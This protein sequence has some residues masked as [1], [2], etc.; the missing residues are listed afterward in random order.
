MIAIESHLPA[1]ITGGAD[2]FT[3]GGHR[4]ATSETSYSSPL[5]YYSSATIVAQPESTVENMKSRSLFDCNIETYYSPLATTATVVYMDNNKNAIWFNAY[6]IVLADLSTYPTSWKL[7]GSSNQF[8]W[9][10][11]HFVDDF[12]PNTSRKYFFLV[13]NVPHLY[14]YFKIQFLSSSSG[15]S[16]QV[17]E[18]NLHQINYQPLSDSLSYEFNVYSGF[19]H[20]DSL[21]IYPVTGDYTNFSILP[22]LP[23]SLTFT[24]S[25]HIF[26]TPTEMI[27]RAF[28]IRAFNQRTQSFEEISLDLHFILCEP[29][30]YAFLKLTKHN[31]AFAAE[32]QFFMYSSTNALLYAS[33]IF[34][35]NKH[36]VTNLCVPADI[37]RIQLNDTSYDGWYEYS[38]L[39]IHMQTFDGY[40]KLLMTL[41]YP[42]GSPD[43]YY[44]DT[45]YLIYE[46]SPYWK[47]IQ[48]SIPPTWYSLQDPQEF[49]ILP[50]PR[51]SATSNIWLF[52]HSFTIANKNPY[53]S[54]DI[55]L[56]F[57]AGCIIYINGLSVYTSSLPEGE[58][59]L[60][61][62][63]TSS[64]PESS[65]MTITVDICAFRIG[66]NSVAIGLVNPVEQTSG[67]IDF[68]CCLQLIHSN[69]VPR[70]NAMQVQTVPNSDLAY[71]LIDKIVGGNWMVTVNRGEVA[72]ITLQFNKDRAEY[73]NEYCFTSSSV[74]SDYDPSDW[75]V[76][77]SNDNVQY[78]HIGNYTNAYFSD[79]EIQRCF[80]LPSN[81]KSWTYYKFVLT[82][83]ANADLPNY[84]FALSE[85]VLDTI[86]LEALGIPNLKFDNAYYL[87]YIGVPFPDLVPNSKYFINFSI[88]PNLPNPLEIDTTTGSIRGIPNA[89]LP[90]R[91]YEITAV[92]PLDILY[93]TQIEL[94]VMACVSPKIM[95]TIMIFGGLDAAETGFE[96]LNSSNQTIFSKYVL[97]PNQKSYFPFCQETGVYSLVLYDMRMNGWGAG[98]YSVLLEDNSVLMTGSIRQKSKYQ[99]VVLNLGYVINPLRSH[100]TYLN[101]AV[102]PP[103]TWL[104]S[105]FSDPSWSVGTANEYGESVGITQY[106]RYVFSFKK[107]ANYASVI[108]TIH[109]KFGA[110]VYLNGDLLLTYNMPSVTSTHMTPCLQRY[111]TT[112]R[113]GESFSLFSRPLH[114][115]EN[116][117]AVEIHKSDSTPEVIDFDADLQLTATNS[118]RVID[119]TASTDVA[120]DPDAGKVFDNFQSTTYTSNKKCEGSQFIWTYNKNRKEFITS[121]TL[122]SDP[123]CNVYHPSGW[124][125]EGSNNM[126]QWSMLDTQTLQ[127]FTEY[128][129]TKS[130]TFYNEKAFN[131]YRL[132]VT[133][134]NNTPIG[135]AES[136]T[137]KNCKS[138]GS[139][140]QLVDI[141]LYTT[142]V[143]PSC[144]P[145]DGFSGAL[146]GQYAYKDCDLYYEGTYEALCLD[147]QLLQAVDH[148]SLMKPYAILYS[149][150]I[151]DFIQGNYA[152]FIPTVHAIKYTCAST[153]LP[154]GISM[155]S[156]T[157]MLYGETKETFVNFRVNVTCT[158]PA[159]SVSTFIKLNSFK[160]FSIPAFVWVIIFFLFLIV[161]AIISYCIY[162]RMKK[163]KLKG[164]FKAPKKL[165][166][167][168]RK[169]KIVSKI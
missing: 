20:I 137:E 82:E 121:Y 86:N 14:S 70:F 96:L 169:S 102:E 114:V 15:L 103:L 156:S 63:P 58:I 95:F 5:L 49:G 127:F 110:L 131:T 100:W 51:P 3:V 54:C 46:K 159:G 35:T 115:G 37:I 34:Q 65:Y 28:I 43:T 66:T 165:N 94:E 88:S 145:Q 68:Y 122:T 133:E 1:N 140:V 136:S 144:P 129:Q 166:I 29:P 78:S 40:N 24:S 105:S 12:T 130:Y 21:S 111:D 39:Q 161:L 109:T 101:S 112:Q 164:E 67:P 8:T 57:R 141:G 167:N 42:R 106:F 19:S 76:Y 107:N 33:P 83:P 41:Y 52:R 2:F 71:K 126:Y 23:S 149:S 13:T 80:Y 157:G 134:C 22:D 27:Y 120:N 26:G 17:S 119:G 116:V 11:L 152:Q 44:I 150:S 36:V 7:L 59:S 79:R 32:E 135:S 61:T 117:F 89:V 81:S 18:F 93:T 53:T 72:T 142:Y 73:I 48:G 125:L 118:Y 50:Y 151:L 25:G 132:R 91:T 154:T 168:N 64:R 124:V 113:V 30:N 97:T 31:Y 148:C 75:M 98:Y 153:E 90:R 10:T 16:I 56:K 38:N 160:Q 128:Y 147:G 55:T 9:T 77:G 138:R 139:S 69:E 84:T 92:S 99:T 4:F 158:N 6:S 143:E 62:V 45:S 104:S 60:Q 108:Y 85:V 155:D 74:T 87:G 146:E 162:K 123:N 47:F 163:P